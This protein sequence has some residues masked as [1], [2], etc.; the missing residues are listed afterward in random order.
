MATKRVP[1]A[2]EKG[3]NGGKNLSQD[4]DLVVTPNPNTNARD[5]IPSLL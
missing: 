1:I 5:Y 2:S 4:I 3:T